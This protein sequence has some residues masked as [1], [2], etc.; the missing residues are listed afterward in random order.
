MYEAAAT[1]KDIARTPVTIWE[2]QCVTLAVYGYTVRHRMKVQLVTPYRV[3]HLQCYS[4]TI[5]GN[6]TSI[7][8][9]LTYSHI[10]V[11]GV[12]HLGCFAS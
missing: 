2:P 10:S 8:P 9:P 1:C 12:I 3:S 5:H 11:F 4:V 7:D 6:I